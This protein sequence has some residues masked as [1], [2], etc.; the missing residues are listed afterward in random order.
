MSSH[1]Y[2][3][4]YSPTMRA[5]FPTPPELTLG[6]P[7]LFILKYLLQYICKWAQIHKSTTTI[8]KKTNLLLLQW[9]PVLS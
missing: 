8:S 5:G 9:I 6:S 3:Q 7:N 4:T 2:S 1:T